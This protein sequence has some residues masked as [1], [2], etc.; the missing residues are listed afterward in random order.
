M[1]MTSEP[2][3]QLLKS[4]LDKSGVKLGIDLLVLVICIELMLLTRNV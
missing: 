3:H 1:G 2:L 4:G